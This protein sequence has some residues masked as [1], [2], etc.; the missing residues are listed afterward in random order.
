MHFQNIEP[1]SCKK[2]PIF[3][4][5]R[6]F[7]SSW[8][9]AIFGIWTLNIDRCPLFCYSRPDPSPRPRGQRPG[10]ERQRV[11]Q[12]DQ[13]GHGE[14]LHPASQQLLRGRRGGT[15]RV[16]G[17]QILLLRTVQEYNK[18]WQKLKRLKRADFE[19]IQIS[20]P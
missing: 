7:A 9:L 5:L 10:G 19:G 2:T 4:F 6:E 13:R 18:I 14:D 16:P 11:R 20:I 15:R 8:H 12:E 1:P 3:I 17:E